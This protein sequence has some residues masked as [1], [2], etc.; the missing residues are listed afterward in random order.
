MQNNN[1]SY[2][3][4]LK[5]YQHGVLYVFDHAHDIYQ[6]LGAKLAWWRLLQ[7]YLAG[8]FD[9]VIA[10][11]SVQ[12]VISHFDQYRD[13]KVIQQIRDV[14][15]REFGQ[16]DASTHRDLNRLESEAGDFLQSV[17]GAMPHPILQKEAYFSGVDEI[18]NNPIYANN[19]EAELRYK[20]Q[21][22]R[23]EKKLQLQKNLE[24]TNTPHFNPTPFR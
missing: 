4:L 23:N 21:Q 3:Q 9:T 15:A 7:S 5:I 20:E 2:F 12:P 11:V 10:E 22:L 13:A 17:Q 24:K 8:H 1:K 16:V 19:T 18:R 6:I 14:E